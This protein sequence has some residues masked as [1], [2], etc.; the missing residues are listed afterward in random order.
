MIDDINIESGSI[1]QPVKD[2]AE[3]INNMGYDS[4]VD[5]RMETMPKLRE[6]GWS[7]STSD[8]VSYKAGFAQGASFLILKSENSSG[9]FDPDLF[10]KPLAEK[11]S[12]SAYLKGLLCGLRV[13]AALDCMIKRSVNDLRRPKRVMT[14]ATRTLIESLSSYDALHVY[15]E[16]SGFKAEVRRK[17]G[18]LSASCPS[19]KKDGTQ[20][21]VDYFSNTLS[22]ELLSDNFSS[23]KG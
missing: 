7:T 4:T 23:R 11:V 3:V 16:N 15:L 13:G 17:S 9:V 18:H 5:T 10:P 6:V 22:S 19:Q 21:L 14:G 8:D 12:P 2:W 1:Y 20:M